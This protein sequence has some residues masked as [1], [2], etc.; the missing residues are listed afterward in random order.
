MHI[1]IREDWKRQ[2]EFGLETGGAYG[3]F[4]T[5]PPPLLVEWDNSLVPVQFVR[6]RRGGKGGEEENVL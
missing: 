2:L 5:P 4:T 1:D 3:R 6:T